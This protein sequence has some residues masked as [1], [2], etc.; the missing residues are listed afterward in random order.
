MRVASSCAKYCMTTLW[1]ST[2]SPESGASSP[3][4]M[5][6][7]VDLPTPL[8]PTSA[9]RSPRSM[10]RLRSSK[11]T[12]SPY[13]LRTCFSSSTVRPLLRA[14][15]EVEVD[16]LALGRHLDRHDLLEHLDA[17]L[18]LRRLRRLVAEAV[19]E[20]LDARDFFVLLALGLAQR[21]DARVVLDE[22]VAV[23]AEVVGQRAQRQVGDARDDG[24]EEE[25]IVRDEDHRVR[26]GV[27]VLLEP[28]ARFEIEVVGRLVEQQQVRLA[29]QQLGQRDAHLPAAGERLGRP[30]EVRR[31]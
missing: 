27:E 17:A 22:V 4:S 24:V 29:E 6:I 23:V 9:M 26:I 19:D 15:R 8:G 10:C 31:S 2:R 30:L 13:A 1:P 16:L 11:T 18:H 7:S 21:L 20:H 3:D 25:A 28:V 5:R 12:R 14:G